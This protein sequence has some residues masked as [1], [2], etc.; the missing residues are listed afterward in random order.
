MLDAY[1][2]AKRSAVPAFVASRYLYGLALLITVIGFFHLGIEWS[3]T[4]FALNAISL[5]FATAI[6]SLVGSATLLGQSIPLSLR[7]LFI[8]RQFWVYV[9]ALFLY[10][11]LPGLAAS[12]GFLVGIGF[13][14]TAFDPDAFLTAESERAMLA[15]M[16]SSIPA[17]VASAYVTAR[18]SLLLPAI[19]AGEK[20]SIASAWNR[21]T[22]NVMKIAGAFLVALG[23]LFV[24]QQLIVEMAKLTSAAFVAL[25]ASVAI[26]I[27]TFCQA[28]I[29]GTVAGSIYRQLN[30]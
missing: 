9:Y 14:L 23:V 3:G 8:H 26:I 24:C 22:G 6:T 28:L 15:V 10:W 12:T 29:N 19:A 27:V 25:I 20:L 11:A 4:I 5:F 2:Q 17:V 7:G 21:S 30:D 1:E 13:Y 16:F 18:L